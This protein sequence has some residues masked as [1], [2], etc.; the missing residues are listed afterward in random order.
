MVVG[1]AGSADFKITYAAPL[2]G[3]ELVQK[4]CFNY[5]ELDALTEKYN[6]ASLKQGYN[7]VNGEEVYFIENPALGL[8]AVEGNI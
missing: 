3:R 4:A 6:V 1:N 8:W 5:E 7:N 2:L